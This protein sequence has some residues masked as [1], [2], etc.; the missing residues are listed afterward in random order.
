[1]DY[2][3]LLFSSP[4]QDG[5]FYIR[6]KDPA[7]SENST[8]WVNFFTDGTFSIIQP[9]TGYPY[10]GP[11]PYTNTSKF[12][13]TYE[14]S[15]F[16]YYMDGILLFSFNYEVSNPIQWEILNW[17]ANSAVTVLYAGMGPPGAGLSR[18]EIADIQQATD[19]VTSS[20]VAA[21]LAFNAAMNDFTNEA[22]QV[23]SLTQTFSTT[24]A[25]LKTNT[26]NNT[27]LYNGFVY[28]QTYNKYVLQPSSL[29]I[30][31][32]DGSPFNLYSMQVTPIDMGVYDPTTSYVLGNLVN[33]PDSYGA[34]YMCAVSLYP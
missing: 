31:V 29:P 23:S 9:T 33:D 2:R 30:P 7:D 19:A 18:Q 27:L 32:I 25:I 10:Y 28:N 22:K 11:V 34:Q 26:D 16:L 5:N 12:L 15:I 6:L 24:T 8:P 1:M 14:N 21:Q 17:T 13:I 20:F 4:A 3:Y